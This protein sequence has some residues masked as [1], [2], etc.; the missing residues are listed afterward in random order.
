MCKYELYYSTLSCGCLYLSQPILSTDLKWILTHAES[1]CSEL[2]GHHWQCLLLLT[3][4]T[5]TL[6]LMNFLQLPP[7][8][9]HST[10]QHYSTSSNHHVTIYL[11]CT[12]PLTITSHSVSYFIIS[13]VLIE[14]SVWVVKTG[15]VN[16]EQEYISS[17]EWQAMYWCTLHI[18]VYPATCIV[19]VVHLYT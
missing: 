3:L 5:V 11:T 16:R 8:T 19:Y 1:H 6:C 17:S 9:Q 7:A 10:A 14:I 18:T 4:H 12:V 2:D 15:Q 13:K